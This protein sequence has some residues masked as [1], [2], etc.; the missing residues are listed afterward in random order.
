MKKRKYF[1]TV[2]L[3]KV[4]R[5][6]KSINLVIDKNQGIK[7]AKGIL[8]ATEQGKTFDLAVHD[9]RKRKD[10]KIN[11]TITQVIKK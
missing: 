2:L 11:M 6:K 1:G 10:G 8:S 4:Y 5:G 3:N 9:Y 7:F